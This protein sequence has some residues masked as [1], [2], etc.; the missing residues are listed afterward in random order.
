M[1]NDNKTCVM[2]GKQ[3]KYCENCPSKYNTTETWR[4]IF[5]SEEC[6]ELYQ[7]YNGY[8]GGKI[9]DKQAY[10]RLSKISTVY[11]NKIK[12]PMKSVFNLICGI[13]SSADNGQEI[14]ETQNTQKSVKMANKRGPRKNSRGKED[15]VI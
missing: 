12:E 7:I 4:N 1:I 11:L 10:K 6:R 13:E 2:C 3:Y 15:K 14:Q 9:T 5:C 8:K